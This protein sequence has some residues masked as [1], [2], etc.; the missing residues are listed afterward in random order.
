MPYTMQISL[1]TGQSDLA[2]RLNLSHKTCK[3]IIDYGGLRF[4]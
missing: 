2:T 3:P 1:Y 4:L